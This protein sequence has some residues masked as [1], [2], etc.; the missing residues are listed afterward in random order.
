MDFKKKYKLDE[1]FSKQNAAELL[2]EVDCEQIAKIVVDCYEADEESR[3]D[4]LMRMKDAIKLA[5]QVKEQKTEPWVGASNVKFPLLTEAAL[6]FQSRAYPALVTKPDLV[7][8]RVMGQD[9]DGKKTARAQRTSDFM[10]Y[11][12]LEEDE[13][14]EE[15]TDRLFLQL[16]IVGCMFR[17]TYYDAATA[18][19]CSDLILPDDF[20]VSYYTTTLNQAPQYT[21]ILHPTQNEIEGNFASGEWLEVELPESTTDTDTLK[22]ESLKNRGFQPPADSDRQKEDRKVLEQ[23]KRFDLDGDGYSEPYIATVDYTS[24]KLLKLVPNFTPREVRRTNQ[25]AIDDMRNQMMQIMQMP[26]VAQDTVGQQ[27]EQLEKKAY[28]QAMAAQLKALESQGD[29]I[30]IPSIEYVTK[31]PF[32][33]S[34]DG[35]YYDIGFGQLLGPLND[36]VDTIINQLID[37]GTLSNSNPGFIASNGRIR[38]G[39]LQFKPFELKRIEVPAG[40]LKDAI[41]PLEVNAPS[42]VLFNLLGMLIKQA[43]ELASVTEV[44]TGQLP[45]QNT[46]AG[47]AQQALDQGMKVFSGIVLRLYRAFTQEYRKLFKLN[48]LYLDPK[49]YFQTLGIQPDFQV[50]SEDFLGSEKAVLPEADPNMGSESQRLQQAMFL[51]QRASTVGGYNP[52]AVERR[53]LTLMRIPNVNE[54]YPGTPPPP[55][56]E[57]ALKAAEQQRKALDSHH[58]MVIETSRALADMK[59]DE[60]DMYVALAELKAKGDGVAVK[61]AEMLINKF[62]TMHEAIASMRDHALQEAELMQNQQ[63]LDQQKQ[64]QAAQPAAA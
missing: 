28:L 2:A 40:M 31:Y 30:N 18:R 27:T 26:P 45:G 5:L 4:W 39:D 1:L 38:G 11:Q 9:P 59:K 8:C 6:Q 43:Q 13:T 41:L 46:K 63:Q 58:K 61:H 48:R 24:K 64:A 21:I 36:A 53:I 37:S 35:G 47:V 57:I 12:L 23:Y 33:P 29:I 60:V 55:N 34:P 16:P 32:I 52:M 7:K 14:W 42:N 49:Q 56:P 25:A 44:M 22:Y 17:K 15:D 54:I 10:S 3:S 19:N 20:V 50:Y 51:S 62:Q